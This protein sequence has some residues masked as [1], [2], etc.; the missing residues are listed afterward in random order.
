MPR[1]FFYLKKIRKPHKIPRNKDDPA[2]FKFYI[3]FKVVQIIY[4]F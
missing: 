2:S 3:D 1:N 4:R